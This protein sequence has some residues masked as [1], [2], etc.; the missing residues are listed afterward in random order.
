[1]AFE[2]STC[3]RLLNPRRDLDP[4]SPIPMNVSR[5]LLFHISHRLAV[6]C[7]IEA[8][9]THEYSVADNAMPRF[10]REYKFSLIAAPKSLDFIELLS[11]L[12]KG[13]V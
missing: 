4:N 12:R 10:L 2:L 1:M 8:G 9:R 6:R 13:L 5:R 11:E 3:P 7:Q